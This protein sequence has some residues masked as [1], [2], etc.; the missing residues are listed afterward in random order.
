MPG[1]DR[2][3]LTITDKVLLYRSPEMNR[4]GTS[5]SELVRGFNVFG[6]TQFVHC[7]LWNL[8]RCHRSILAENYRSSTKVFCLGGL[9]VA[10]L[11]SV[12]DDRFLLSRYVDGI[13]SYSLA[14]RTSLCTHRDDANGPGWRHYS[15]LLATGEN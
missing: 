10:I 13:G 3:Q 5:L 14:E 6:I 1:N 11:C 4:K 7:V 12:V 2:T 8:Y 9:A 15:V